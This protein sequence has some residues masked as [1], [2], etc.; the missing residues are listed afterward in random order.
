MK[1]KFLLCLIPVILTSCSLR[2]AALVKSKPE[3]AHLSSARLERIRPLMQKYVEEHKLPGMV[4]LV[5]R[6]GKV[7][8]YEKFGKMDTVKPMQLN[9]IFRI[10][11]MTK[12]ITSVA[13]MMLYEEGRFQ[14]D[15]PV[16]KY[17]PEFG[18]L[19]VLLSLDKTGMHLVKPLRPLTI[20]DLLMHTS[21]LCSGGD[22]TP[23][24]SMYRAANL[25]DGN[26]KDMMVKLA[27]IPLMYQPGTRW[28]YSRSTEVLGYL[29]EVLSGQPLNEFLK[30]RIFIPLKMEDTDYC[31]PKDKQ[32]RLATVFCP[33]EKGGIMSI[34]TDTNDISKIPKFISGNGGL[35]STAADYMK[36]AQMLLN[37]GEY[38]GVRLLGSRTVEM[39]TSDHITGEE[40][41]RDD[42]FGPMMAGM[43]FGF[44]LAVLQDNEKA[45]IIGSKG[46]YWWS[47]AANTYFYIDP[48]E[49]MI[50]ILM[51][52]YVPNFYYPIFKEF[53]VLAYQAIT[54]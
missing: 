4:T 32:E 11:S 46:S 39:M 42:F 45:G 41:P 53:R 54:N 27:K 5:A 40:M 22:D 34:V 30:E 16:S 1:K 50:L 24:D 35:Y 51:T 43:G 12:P 2:E 18:D 29:V 47:G 6:H 19:E 15:D 3:H 49:D 13:V 17:I 52:Q 20:R 8:S 23:V 21:G 36:F 9:T 33:A 44:G 10:A 26:L 38:R 7:V 25:F 31:V 37:R 14:L 28:N 48:K